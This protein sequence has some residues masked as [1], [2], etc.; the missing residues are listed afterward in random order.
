MTFSDSA[1]KPRGRAFLIGV[2]GSGMEPL[3]RFAVRAGYTVHGSDPGITPEKLRKLEGEGVVVHRQHDAAHLQAGYDLVVYSSAIATDHVEREAARR[4]ADER[5]LRLLHRMDFLNLCFADCPEALCVAGTHGKTS[6]SSMVGWVLRGLDLAP[7]ILVG[8]RPLY[9]PGGVEYGAGRTG[10]YETDESDGSFLKARA[11]LRLILNVDHDHLEHYG[12]FANLSRSFG[13]FAAGGALTVYNAGD[14]HL[15]GAVR[16]AGLT[17]RDTIFTYAA[18]DAR[19][20]APERHYAGEF[21]GESDRLRVIT[22]GDSRAAGELEL[23]MPGR[24]FAGN[25]LGVFALIDASVRRGFLSCPDY[26]PERS[27]EL[28][29]AF[30]GVERRMELLGQFQG[31]RYYDDYGHHPTEIRA[32]LAAF[33]RRLEEPGKLLAVFQPHRYSRTAEHYAAFARALSGADRLFLLPLY[34]AGE[35]PRPGVGSEL[36]AEEL[37]RLRMAGEA[38]PE[39]KLLTSNDAAAFAGIAAA[40]SPGDVVA[41]LGAGDISGSVRAFLGQRTQDD[42]PA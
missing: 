39:T 18:A 42:V 5:K 4:L 16:A 17:S 8:G 37:E 1:L 38:V 13:E 19:E 40:A 29:N 3:A 24:H 31:A 7:H 11:R 35:Q 34:S 2:G 15:A 30:P 27:I 6:S 10:V 12:N 9:L 33:R 41:C 26:R 36:I 32:V 21:L 20:V 28:L 14:A 22:P 23:R 25:A